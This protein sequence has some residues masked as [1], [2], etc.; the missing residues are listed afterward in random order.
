MVSDR[1]IYASKRKI[2]TSFSKR[3]SE[4]LIF[5]LYSIMIANLL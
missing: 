3:I 1:R 2:L 4:F 5:D